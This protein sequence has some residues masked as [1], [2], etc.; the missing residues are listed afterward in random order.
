MYGVKSGTY[1]AKIAECEVESTK[2]HIATLDRHHSPASLTMQRYNKSTTTLN[3]QPSSSP[4]FSYY[5]HSAMDGPHDDTRYGYCCSWNVPQGNCF[6]CQVSRKREDSPPF[7]LGRPPT[8]WKLFPLAMRPCLSLKLSTI[9]AL[10]SPH[11]LPCLSQVSS[12]QRRIN[13][14][15]TEHFLFSYWKTYPQNRV[16]MGVHN[17]HKVDWKI[18]G[19][20]GVPW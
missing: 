15:K 9:T 14:V 18:F 17:R 1:D 16:H 8:R 4:Y 3:V 7:F 13:N 5:A 10:A 19:T 6:I 12:E 2:V 11:H 20:L